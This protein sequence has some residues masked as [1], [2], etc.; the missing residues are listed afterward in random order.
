MFSAESN[1]CCQT[2]GIYS[3]YASHWFVFSQ[4][5]AQ[6][7]LITGSQIIN[8]PLMSSW[9]VNFAI[10]GL[11]NIHSQVHKKVIRRGMESK[12]SFTIIL[13]LLLKMSSHIYTYKINN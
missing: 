12:S 1:H 5:V 11:L 4:Q 3:N 2:I 7:V 6:G 13:L 8:Y 10:N 9:L